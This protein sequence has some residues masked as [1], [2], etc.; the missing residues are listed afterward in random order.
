MEPPP[1]KTRMKRVTASHT[2]HRNAEQ[3]RK[4]RQQM[5]NLRDQ[6]DRW[7]HIFQENNCQHDGDVAKLL[8]DR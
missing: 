8:I 1:K 6:I 2:K 4:T 5:V 3:S 7:K